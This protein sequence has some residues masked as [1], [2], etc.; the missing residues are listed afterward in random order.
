MA[1]IIRLRR[2]PKALIA[3]FTRADRVYEEFTRVRLQLCR[4]PNVKHE[5]RG[6]SQPVSMES[7]QSILAEALRT[8]NW[9]KAKRAIDAIKRRGRIQIV[10]RTKTG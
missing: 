3:T 6:A 5:S 8:G 4:E 10:Q 9:T 1:D 2:C 7:V